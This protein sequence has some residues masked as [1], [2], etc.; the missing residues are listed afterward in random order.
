MI[1]LL[2]PHHRE[3]AERVREAIA[4]FDLTAA[5]DRAEVMRALSEMGALGQLVP[6]A[7][8]GE[9]VRIEIG[10]LCAIRYELAYRNPA[11][12]AIFAAE[13][14]GSHP[15]IEF[16]EERLQQTLLPRVV[17][18]AVTFGFALAETGRGDPNAIATT[19]ERDR[20][21]Y[22]LR[23]AK[24]LFVNGA[25][26]THFTVFART[27][28]GERSLTA[29]IVPAT[30]AGLRLSPRDGLPD[31]PVVDLVFDGCRVSLAQRL[32]AEGDGRKI[33]LHTLD[34]FRCTDAAAAVGL[35]Q[36]AQEAAVE[37]SYARLHTGASFEVLGPLHALLAES[38]SEIQA[39]ALL[40]QRGAQAHD[41]RRGG[42]EEGAAAKLFALETAARVVSRTVQVHGDSGLSVGTV[43]ERL[44]RSMR[45]PRNED[46]AELHRAI[47]SRFF[48]PAR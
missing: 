37:Y 10:A 32:G 27:G 42:T 28:S 20:D 29:F 14:Y 6:S 11:A 8:G 38:T 24:S 48:A 7:F 43:A 21:A 25:H 5:P 35:A 39:A 12:D 40:V 17:R 2:A 46:P 30:T 33:A 23:G 4:P 34:F 22:V 1:A 3:L 16:A 18:G 36:R 41:A 9:R 44:Y 19:A 15:L 31:Q 47:I 26:A 13:A 45:G